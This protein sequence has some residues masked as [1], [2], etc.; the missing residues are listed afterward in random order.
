MDVCAGYCP[1]HP[2][3][4]VAEPSGDHIPLGGFVFR[5]TAAFKIWSLRDGTAQRAAQTGTLRRFNRTVH[6]AFMAGQILDMR[7]DAITKSFFV[8][9]FLSSQRIRA[10]RR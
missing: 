6:R 10:G 1:S 9:P 7:C 4:S 3:P 2:A 8:N 5:A